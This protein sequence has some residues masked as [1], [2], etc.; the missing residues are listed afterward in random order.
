VLLMHFN[1]CSY[2]LCRDSAI[3]K[4]DKPSAAYLMSVAGHVAK[5][6]DHLASLAKQLGGSKRNTLL[7]W[8]QNRTA[9][10][11]VGSVVTEIDV[12]VSA[13]L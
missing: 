4:P 11:S 3:E 5:S 9:A 7:K 12:S 1:H 10:Y 6:I 2:N 8:C 13:M